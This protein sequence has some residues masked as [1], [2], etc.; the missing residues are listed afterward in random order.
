MVGRRAALTVATCAMAL[1]LAAPRPAESHPLHTTMTELSHDP[2]ARVLSATLRVFADDFSA[3]VMPA[4]ARRAEVVVP[5]DSAILRYVSARFVVA[6]RGASRVP[7]RWCG[8]RREGDVLFLCLRGTVQGPLAG[9][10]LR[11]T[12]LT[13]MFADQ[14]NIVQASYG[15]RRRTLLFT[16]RDGAKP[17]P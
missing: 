13:E 6:T 14:V 9:A 8:M 5:P 10:S 1:T 15:G 4:V 11:N 2:A 12:L 7:M 17:L 3:A 16:A